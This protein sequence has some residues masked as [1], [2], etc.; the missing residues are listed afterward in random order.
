[1]TSL[2]ALPYHQVGGLTEEEY[3]A[4]KEMAM[5]GH[6]PAAILSALRYANPELLL[7]QHDVYNL[8]HSLW[9][10]ELAGRTPV[11]VYENNA[12]IMGLCD[13]SY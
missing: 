7:V 1:V 6:S 2:V 5:Q 3:K 11:T 4:I 12:F 13:H 9:L 10:D 8:L